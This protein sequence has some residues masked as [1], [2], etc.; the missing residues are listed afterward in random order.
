MLVSLLIAAAVAVANSSISGNPLA[1][2]EKGQLQCYRPDVE[3]KTCQSIA[4]YDRRGPGAYDNKAIIPLGNGATLETHAPVEVRGDAVCGF[5]RSADVIAGQI[6]VGGEVLPPDRAKPALERIA[7]AMAALTDK[8]ICTRY[9]PS[10]KNLTAK[11][12]ISG[13]YQPD[14]DEAVKWISPADGYTV[15]P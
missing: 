4:A 8:E 14:K 11:I 7:Q 13:A 12:S 3:R 1:N 2:A 9:E 10:G 6:K 15:T 5:I